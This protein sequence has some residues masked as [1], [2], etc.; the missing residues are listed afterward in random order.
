LPTKKKL[1]L[2]QMFSTYNKNSLFIILFVAWYCFSCNSNSPNPN[3]VQNPVR[4]ELST[5]LSTDSLFTPTGNA[6]LDSLLQ[7]ASVAK[8]DTNLARLFYQIGDLYEDNNR[9]KGKEYYLK[10]KSLSE[11]LDW[12]EGRLL[13]ASSFSTALCREG[14]P[15]SVLVIISPALELAKRENKEEWIA[16]LYMN[17]GNAYLVKDWYETALRYYMDAMIIFE[18]IKNTERLGLIYCYIGSIYNLINLPEKAVEYCEKALVL[19][20]DNPK[21]N[22]YALQELARAYNI[23]QQYE[24]SNE[25]YEK[26]LELSKQQNNLYLLELVFFHLADNALMVFDLDRAEMYAKKMLEIYGSEKELYL[27]HG[28]LLLLGKLEQLKGNFAKSEKYVLQALEIAIEY[29]AMEVKKICYILLS[30]LSVA[31]HKYP[32]NIRY[33]KELEKVEVAIA[34]AS[35]QR[36]SEEMAAKYE[37]EKKDFQITALKKEK[38]LMVGLSITGG[39]VFL[40]VLITFLLLWRWLVQKKRTI[41]QQKQ[42]AEQQVKQLEQEKQLVATQAVLDGETR[43]RARLARDLHDGLG[44]LLTGAKLRLLEMKQG[45]KLE[46]ADV[47]RFDKA[48]GLLDDSVSEMRRVAHHLMPDSLSRFGLKPAVTDYCANLPSVKFSYYGDESRLE[49]KLEVMIYR[50]IHELVNNALKHAGA[51]HIM[52]QIMQEPDRIAFTVQDDGCGFDPSSVTQGMGLQNIR[53]RV[54]SYNGIISIDSRADEGTE[55]NVE[56]RI[57]QSR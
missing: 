40:L 14:L 5:T 10:L 4:V 44:S 48:L 24:K 56:L 28:Y 33:F 39:A 13:F 2:D 51:Q 6:E 11:Q 34:N 37:T 57:S 36:A 7:L 42:L 25:Y 49:P 26:A 52:V 35:T 8:Q 17:T 3:R 47:E 18:R 53:T 1:K 22:V 30:E 15:D 12:N 9:E 29:D 20:I 46:Y 19:L 16:V 38:G 54:A 21:Y 50:S 23:L 27:Y 45:V 32:D 55:I 41:E 31:L 43:E